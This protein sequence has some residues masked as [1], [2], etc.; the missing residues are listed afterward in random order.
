MKPQGSV[1]LAI[2]LLQAPLK[3]G[4]YV[5]AA[6]LQTTSVG[7]SFLSP[8]N[9]CLWNL[10]ACIKQDVLY[11]TSIIEQNL[12]AYSKNFKLHKRHFLKNF[13]THAPHSI[14]PSEYTLF[15][16]ALKSYLI[17]IPSHDF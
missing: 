14:Q 9:I 16:L 5:N 2:F 7:V 17:F 1:S 15:P 3:E 12:Y 4:Y 11:V 8:G 10:F 13:P 6:L